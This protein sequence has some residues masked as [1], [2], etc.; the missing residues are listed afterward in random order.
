VFE[1]I[2]CG[3]LLLNEREDGIEVYFRDG[4]HVVL[5]DSEVI[6][7]EKIKYLLSHEDVLE[8]IAGSGHAHGLKFHTYVQ[9]AS[10]ILEKTFDDAG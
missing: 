8:S 5:Y 10:T 9:R 7:I 1:T 2:G 3:T 6:C 4:E